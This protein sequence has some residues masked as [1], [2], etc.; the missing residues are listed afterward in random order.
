MNELHVISSLHNS[1]IICITETFG[2]PNYLDAF[3]CL[4]NY[5]MFRQDRLCHGGGGIIVY[6]RQHLSCQVI[7]SVSHPSGS[8]EAMSCRISL[9]SPS[10]TSLQI[11]CIYR[12]PGDMT[13][14]SLADFINY[15]HNASVF[16]NAFHT[17]IL[18]DFNF[19]KIN[20]ELNLC[21]YPVNS[22]AHQFLST[23]NDNHLSQ[24]VN[25]A[26]RFREG[27]IPSLLDL[28]LLHDELLV[29]SLD[30]LPGIGKSDHVTLSLV[31]NLPTELKFN[32]NARFNFHKADFILINSIIDSI[33]W[34]EEFL[35]LTCE[36]AVEVLQ[37][38]LLTICHN[39]IPQSQPS[40]PNLS[41]SPW[42]SRSVKKLVNKKKRIWDLYKKHPTAHNWQ[43]YKH[44]RN[45]L[46]SIIREKK[47]NYERDLINGCHLSTKPLFTYINSKRKTQPLT[48]L[49]TNNV[50]VSDDSIIA[51]KLCD[52]FIRFSLR[53]WL[54]LVIINNRFLI[55]ISPPFLPKTMF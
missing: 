21:N 28:V 14:S 26:T 9:Q 32:R 48:C 1:D 11:S 44:I 24:I 38:F 13:P 52:F 49:K 23:I 19:P 42:M 53:L 4:P 50:T 29:Q 36:D 55:Q 17:V 10:N 18:G 27:Q 20:W 2:T 6:A 47:A 30:S 54:P 34:E 39:L 31:L 51:E 8:W 12:A 41:R 15:I 35:D 46:T 25:F 43:N 5:S 33:N 7:S 40:S 45:S 22:P 3:F 37:C 16:N